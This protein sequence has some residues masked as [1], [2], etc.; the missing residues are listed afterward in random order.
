MSTF[1]AALLCIGDFSRTMK[2]SFYLQADEV[3]RR[4]FEYIDSNVTTEVKLCIMNCMGDLVLS[5]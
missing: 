1:K 3:M 2:S 4:L 5:L